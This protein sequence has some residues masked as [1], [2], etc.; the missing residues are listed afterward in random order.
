MVLWILDNLIILRSHIQIGVILQ[1][2]HG[3]ARRRILG[4]VLIVIVVDNNIVCC[5]DIVVGH[6]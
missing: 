4:T 1:S 6:A 3:W 5:D 2:L